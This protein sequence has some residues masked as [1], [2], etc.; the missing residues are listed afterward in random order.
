MKFQL[1]TT[2]KTIKI[3][4]SVNIEELLE[5]LKKILP[6]GEWKQFLLESNTTIAWESPISI[7]YY[8]YYPTTPYP[9]WE[10]KTYYNCSGVGSVSNDPIT[11][12]RYGVA[13]GVY[14]VQIG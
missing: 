12:S 2:N 5:V 14:N 10:A 3:D 11:P 9:W 7:P 4:G 6:N 13:E 1:D 8:P